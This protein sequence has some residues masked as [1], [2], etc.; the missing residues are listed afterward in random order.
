[1]FFI[2]YHL[3]GRF[4]NGM[5]RN[6]GG[7]CWINLLTRNPHLSTKPHDP[8]SVFSSNGVVKLVGLL[9]FDRQ[10]GNLKSGAARDVRRLTDFLDQLYMTYD[11]YGMRAEQLL[12]LLPDEFKRFNPAAGSARD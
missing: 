9:Y 11:V 6:M 4:I 5:V 2:A 8:N 10:T 7:G 3:H 12:A 1:M